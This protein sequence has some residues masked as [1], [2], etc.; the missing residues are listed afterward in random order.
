VINEQNI[1]L[2]FG[3]KL[4]QLR[5]KQGLSPKELADTAGISISY[6]NEIEKGK[7]YPKAEKIAQLA[8]VL[9]TEYDELVSL[10]LSRNLAPIAELLNSDLL[11]L[12]PLHLFGIGADD[13]VEII[14][15]APV[16]V[17]AF[18][19]TLVGIARNYEMRVEQF[20]LTAL[21]S[22]QEMHDNYFEDL[23][24]IVDKF[25]QVNHIADDEPVTLAWLSNHL[26]EKYAYI[27]DESLIVKYPDLRSVRSIFSFRKNRNRL[28]LN[29]NLNESQKIF[30][31]AKEVGY[32]FMD[33]KERNTAPSWVKAESFEQVLNNFKAS[34]FAGA[35][36]IPRKQLAD[37][38]ANFFTTPLWDGN[39][40]L[41]MMNRYRVSPETFLHRLTSIVPRFFNI[42]QLFFLRFSTSSKDPNS[43][44][45]TKELHLSNPHNP[46][47]NALNEHYCRRWVSINLCKEFEKLLLDDKDAQPIVQAQR[48][49][50]ISSDNEYFCI[51]VARSMNP[52]PDTVSSVA[53]GFSMNA[54]FKSKVAF[55]HDP[56]VSVRL[57]NE[58]CERCA[59]TDCKERVAP[60]HVLKQQTATQKIEKTVEDLV[61]GLN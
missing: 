56:Q 30:Q 28:L 33:L 59:L 12:L 9:G 52:T 8:E 43:Y 32:Q 39:A 44:D 42:N 26:K 11:G 41:D 37:D 36:L 55:W 34:Y 22:Y 17:S 29:S 25:R 19:S 2:I 1:R 45:I 5:Q 58:T 31:L 14:A 24:N 54:D 18:I 38:L 49:H 57:V 3:L 20:Y 47:A 61:K 13:L 16:K 51:S 7:K 21:R 4:R 10:R 46:H 23:E 50:Y 53:I 15:N 27:I 40:F 60:A 6:L 35:L 48:S